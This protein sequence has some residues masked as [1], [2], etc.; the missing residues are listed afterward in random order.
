MVCAHLS[1]HS[2]TW[3]ASVKKQD[4][5]QAFS[6]WSYSDWL[7]LVG[8]VLISMSL[9]WWFNWWPFAFK[10]KTL[11]SELGFEP[12]GKY[13]GRVR[14]IKFAA[15]HHTRRKDPLVASSQTKLQGR[16]K[17]MFCE[18]SACSRHLWM[19]R[20]C[21]LYRWKDGGSAALLKQTS[22]PTRELVGQGGEYAA[23]RQG[24]SLKEF[25]GLTQ[26]P[27]S[28]ASVFHGRALDQ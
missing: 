9:L 11:T 16:M 22:R 15:E 19:Q 14:A 24:W 18:Q 28:D 8:S 12:L 27:A 23:Y 6:W 4:H 5:I 26:G 20:W 10:I 21:W 17:K 13:D 25:F 2:L 3:T 1:V 7:R